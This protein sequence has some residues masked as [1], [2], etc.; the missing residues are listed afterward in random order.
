MPG[1]T[2]S[3][4][5]AILLGVVVGFVLFVPFVSLS[6]RRRGHL[7]PGRLLV[8]A[9]ALVYFWAI[10]TYTLLPLPSGRRIEVCAGRELDPLAL[11]REVRDLRPLLGQGTAL[12]ADP[13]FLQIA[14]NVVLFIPLGFFLRVLGGRG[15]VVA[16]L[17]GF[18]VSLVI[19]TT[20]LTGVW[21][22]YSCAYRVFDDGDLMT[23]TAGAAIGSVLALMV[24]R[25]LRGLAVAPDAGRPR[26]VTRARRLLAMACDGIA[27][28][29]VSASVD[30]MVTAAR[31][32]LAGGWELSAMRRVAVPV[33]EGAG[34]SGAGTLV[35]AAIWLVVILATG[36]SP[37]DSAVQLQY[38]GGPVPHPLA[39][40]LRW[41]AG[42]AGIAVLGL[43][44]GLLTPIL[45]FVSVFMVLITRSGRGLPGLVS[46]QELTDARADA[47]AS[48]PRS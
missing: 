10:W 40:L 3:A 1:T 38:R 45:A 30:V 31:V 24:P 43:V 17:A 21:G 22:I 11:L 47:G 29:L 13:T 14:L 2:A 48:V 26:P 41:L 34:A 7:S 5:V 35:A 8:W 12:L 46:A 36:R 19:E 16:L 42:I 20:Q 9:S 32:I 15:I 28:L 27:F 4:I 18:G 33:V 6:Y 44:W 39:R 23:N 25:R 37:G